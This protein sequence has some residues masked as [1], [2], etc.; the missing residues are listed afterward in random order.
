MGRQPCGE[1]AAHIVDTLLLVSALATFG[2]IVS[3][4]M[5]KNPLGFLTRL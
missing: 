2:D 4:A 1:D 3:F 5:S